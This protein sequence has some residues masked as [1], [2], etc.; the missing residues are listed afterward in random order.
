MEEGL[1]FAIRGGT[2]GNSTWLRKEPMV[3]AKSD[4]EGTSVPH[5]RG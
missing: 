1:G 2:P 4:S 5:P 3:R